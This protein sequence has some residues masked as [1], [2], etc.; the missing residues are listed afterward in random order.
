V[1]QRQAFLDAIIADP[2]D[3]AVRL[4]YADW[5]EEH[6]TAVERDSARYRDTCGF[7]LEMKSPAPPPAFLDVGLVELGDQHP[8]VRLRVGQAAGGDALPL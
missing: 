2:D 4:I 3:D 6:G 1:D 5:L 7:Y 8:A